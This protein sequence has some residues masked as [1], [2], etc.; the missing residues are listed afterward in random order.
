MNVSRDDGRVG[1]SGG[2]PANTFQVTPRR[3]VYQAT[4]GEDDLRLPYMNRSFISFS[5]G[6]KPIEDFDLIA[7]VSGD[8]MEKQ[9][10]SSFIDITSDY[11]I[12]EGQQYWGSHFKTNTLNFTLSTDG[13]D[14]QT[15]DKF[16]HWFTAGVSREL[17]L[18]E[19][20]NRAQLARVAEPPQLSLLPFETTTYFK[21]SNIERPVTTTLYKGSI[22]LK[23]V[24]DKPHWYAVDNILGIKLV[25]ENNTSRYVDYWVGPNGGDPVSIFQSQDALKIL[26]EDGIPLGSMIEN[27]MMLGNGAFA[28]VEGNTTSI[29]WSVNE[30]QIVWENQA[31]RQPQITD[32]SYGARIEPTNN[33]PRNMGIIAGAIVNA[34]GEGIASL[35]SGS[36]AYFFYAGTAPAPTILSFTLTPQLNGS[37]YI[38]TPKNKR[39]SG[40][41][42]YNTIT[43]GSVTDQELR[44]TTPN[45][46]TSY[47]QAVEILA[48]ISISNQSGVQTDWVAA[49]ENIREKVRHAYVRQW[50]NKVIDYA[51]DKSGLN[52]SDLTTYMSYFLQ[53]N[54]T[55]AQDAEYYSMTCIFNSE[56]GEAIG[57]F[58][59][60]KVNNSVP[61]NAAGWVTYGTF[62]EENTY[63]EE[64]IGDMIR[65]NYLVIRDRNYPTSMGRIS[66][67][68]TAHKDYSHYIKHNFAVPLE[69]LIITYKNMY[70]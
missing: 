5:Y 51:E 20:P 48:G 13:I 10:Y 7:T 39:S 70:L 64:D 68:T 46:Y 69:N 31:T 22:N 28:N 26:Y 41:V 38:I 3:Q 4:H 59:Y 21:I 12:L 32:T 1:N 33:P 24:M 49:R 62:F 67:Y 65:S 6:G 8:R 61:E 42:K 58:K 53:T 56:T 9:G 63:A 45:I 50:A 15:L 57:K 44:F 47:N 23:L 36:S 18:A 34:D 17:I 25:N 2:Y 43:I 55:T 30:D 66:R 60:R 14:Q 54:T 40:S 35:A 29:T 16:L 11:N 27:N 19:H 52:N 37:N